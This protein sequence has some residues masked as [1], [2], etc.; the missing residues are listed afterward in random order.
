MRLIDADALESKIESHYK[1]KKIDRYDHDLLGHY[2]D[3]EMAPTIDAEP[4]VKCTDCWKRGQ[5]N[6]PM[7][8]YFDNHPE[9]DECYCKYGERKMNHAPD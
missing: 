6:C 7:E 2:L 8:F 1:H 5:D 3:V 4:V 9:D